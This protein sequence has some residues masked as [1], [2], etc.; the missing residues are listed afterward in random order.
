MKKL[1]LA[2]L[3]G[4]IAVIPLHAAFA[5]EN[6]GGHIPVTLC[7]RTGS[8][9]GGNQH[10]GYDL[11]T[12]DLSSIA[13]IAQL[14]G[15]DGHNQVGNGP[16]PDIIP[17]ATYTVLNGPDKGTVVDYPG[18]S[19]D[20]TFADGTTGVEFLANGCQFNGS[21]TPPPPPPSGEVSAAL[22]QGDCND[23]AFVTLFNGTD[24]DAVFTVNGTDYTLPTGSQQDV[25]VAFGDV[26]VTSG[27]FAFSGTATAPTGCNTTPPPPP[28]GGNKPPT[29]TG[30]LPHT[31]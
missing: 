13:G 18:K 19:L 12:V 15:H 14:N 5:T 8:V 10:N 17:A 23:P 21:P 22:T 4:A 26:T 11:I 6:G 2:A 25:E 28:S 16:G 30:G 3:I 24:G 29:P 20:W 31:L 9:G 1:L 27:E 7:H